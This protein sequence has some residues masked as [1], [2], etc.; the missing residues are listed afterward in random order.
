MQITD[1]IIK[2]LTATELTLSSDAIT[3]TQGN[4]KLQPQTGTT[5]NLSTINGTTQGQFGIL[6]VS[7]FGTDTITIKHNVGNILCL[8]GTDIALSNGCV[9]WYSNGTKVFIA[10]GG[11]GG[12]LTDG[13]KGDITVGGSG[14]TL[15][16][17]NDVVTLAKMANMATASLLGRNTAGTGDPEVLS[18]ATVRTLLG[19]VIGT[20]VQAWDADLDTWAGKTP[21][22]GTTVGTSDTQTLTNKRITKRSVTVTQAAAPSINTDN[23]ELFIMTGLAQAITSLTTNLTGTPTNGQ[24]MEM[25]ITDNG[26]ARAITPGASFAGTDAFAITGLTTVANKTLHLLWEYNSALAVWELKGKVQSL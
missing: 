14:T 13:D 1:A 3:I 22:S 18:A 10:G 23:G 26:A 11:S 21:P 9:F 5:D 20:N 4:H 19:L 8:G 2:L 16:I 6:Y 24:V 15:T 25:R 17:D 12:G 7:D